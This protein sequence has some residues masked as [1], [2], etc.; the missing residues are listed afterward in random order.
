ML[1]DYSAHRRFVEQIL[2]FGAVE[3]KSDRA[4]SQKVDALTRR[5]TVDTK[6]SDLRGAKVYVLSAYWSSSVLLFDRGAR[7]NLWVPSN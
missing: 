2:Y 7:D 5:P 6:Y 1:H 4:M 3:Q